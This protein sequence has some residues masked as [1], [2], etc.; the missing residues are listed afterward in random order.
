MIEVPHTPDASKLA[1]FSFVR[2][3]KDQRMALHSRSMLLALSYV[4][5]QAAADNPDTRLIAAFQR[6]ALYQPQAERYERL[7]RRCPQVF[8]L[9]FPDVQ[10]ATPSGITF[11]NLEATWPLIHEWIVIAWGP[12]CTAALLTYDVEHC[13]PERRS[14]RFRGLWTTRSDQIDAIVTAFYAVLQ[15]PA[16]VIKRDTRATYLTNLSIQ[17]MLRARLQAMG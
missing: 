16:P 8:V 2:P 10:P 12:S 13:A 17:K 1:H 4:I 15:Q 5:E 11:V 3:F 9:G 7:A 14:R 6:L